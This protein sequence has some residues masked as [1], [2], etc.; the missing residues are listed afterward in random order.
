MRLRIRFQ[1]ILVSAI[2]LVFLLLLLALALF[3]QRST[4][5]AS[6][7][8]QR[9]AAVIA[10]GD[11]VM[12]AVGQA[13][14]AALAYPQAHDPAML[15]RYA[16]AVA[17]ERA[18][19]ARLRAI[20]SN[21]PLEQQ[22]QSEALIRT[23]DA[24]LALIGT[25]LNDMRMGRS[26]A[27]SALDRSPATRRLVMRLDAAQQDFT[28]GQ[29]RLA[30]EGFAATRARIESIGIALIV[31]CAA[32]FLLTLFVAARFGLTIARRLETLAE[33]ARRSASGR[34]A[35][36]IHGRDEIAQLD[37]VYREMTARI[38]QEHHISSTLQRVLLPH[39]LPDVPGVRIDTAYVPAAQHT[40]VGGDW[41]DV[42]AI[43]PDRICIGVGD[44]AGHGLR[45]ATVMGTAR[46]AIRTAARIEDD[47]AALLARLNDVLC[48]DHPGVLVSA[49]V[50]MLDTRTGELTYAIA[51]HPSPM[52]C[53]G[54]G[55]VAL[56]E[57]GGL[58][59]GADPQAQWDP[60]HARLAE[61]CGLLL[62]TDGIVEVQRDFISGLE[63]LLEAA[64][65]ECAQ[66]SANIAEALQRRIFAD[67]QPHDDSAVLYVGMTSVP[68]SESALR[69]TWVLDARDA[70]AMHRVKAEVL[71]ALRLRARPDADFAGVELIYG[72]LIGNV[73][74]HTGGRAEVTLICCG[75]RAELEIADRGEP[76]DPHPEAPD[77]YAEGGR[78]LFLV[79][80][81]ARGVRVARTD[82]G[83]CV[84]TVLPVDLHEGERTPSSQEAA[85]LLG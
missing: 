83:N 71:D 24:A 21:Q 12:K 43:S 56:L 46:L 47:P 57:G 35:Q 29:Q 2:P 9:T 45:A 78:G 13:N 32:G 18:Q 30:I 37:R 26:A 48:A 58:I 3:V 65:R 61:G 60:L 59:L 5:D 50:G 25:Y 14:A 6:V 4:Y 7:R 68:Q 70:S 28:A 84:S 73:A 34:P 63:R 51:G 53:A 8:A 77:V 67:Q 38:Q 82:E 49:F 33:N 62:Y 75:G 55:S 11:A 40:E 20:V 17:N 19:S 16:A 1:A 15:Q 42:F 10:Q 41:Y 81:I 23:T 36:A 79:R 76:F 54:D 72:E 39:E 31:S 69:H 66:P 44:V 80:A 22:V 27:A 74:R 52:I 85:A 64:E